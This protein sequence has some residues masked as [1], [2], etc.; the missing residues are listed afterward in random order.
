L[1]HVSDARSLISGSRSSSAVSASAP[2]WRDVDVERINL[3][4]PNRIRRQH[5]V[6]YR[7]LQRPT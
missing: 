4:V 1:A 5:I 7:K 3:H 6:Q 2:V